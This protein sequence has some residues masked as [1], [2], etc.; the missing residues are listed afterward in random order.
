MNK[1]ITWL[2]ALVM[3]LMLG[4]SVIAASSSDTSTSSH[5]RHHRY[6][7]DYMSKV[8]A[9]LNLTDAQKAKMKAIK[10]QIRSSF[11]ESKKQM[12]SIQ[13]QLRALVHSDKMDQKKLDALIAQKMKIK[14]EMMKKFAILQ[15][16]MY[17][18]LDANQ[19]A[20]FQAMKAK[21]EA[22]HAKHAHN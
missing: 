20:Q 22:K 15:N 11:E 17:N 5:H 12:Q 4:Q 7:H 1:K 2:F 3:S 14:T 6:H 18:V 21:W 9:K 10:M 19:K 16:Q 13:V 8:L